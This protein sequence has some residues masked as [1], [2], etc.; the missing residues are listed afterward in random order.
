M[1]SLVEEKDMTQFDFWQHSSAEVFD[2]EALPFTGRHP[3]CQ[4]ITENVY[5]S[6]S[7]TFLTFLIHVHEW[8]LHIFY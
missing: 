8:D 3:M 5:D 4:D 1:T 7:Y 2:S 6:K